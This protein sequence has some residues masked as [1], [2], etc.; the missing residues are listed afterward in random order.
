MCDTP[1]E[2]AAGWLGWG[3]LPDAPATIA[4]GPW[5]DLSHLLS[6]DMPRVSFFP[7]PRFEQIWQMPERPINVT[8]M[9]MVVH[10]GTHIDAPRHFFEDGPALDQIPLERLHGP[11]VVVAVDKAPGQ[12]VTAA[13]L[14]AGPPVE[15]GDIVALHTG[16]WRKAGSEAY[17]DHP[18][19]SEDAARW[20]VERRVKLVA[21]DMPTPD[22]PVQ[23]RPDGFNWPVHHI[24]LGNGVLI[25]EHLTGHGH[26]VDRRAE[27]VINALNIAGSDGAPARVLARP[28]AEV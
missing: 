24:L 27:F 12:L 18:S 16:W 20:L 23:R 19:L 7:P 17:D 25:C 13:D 9:Q 21:V 26:L 1:T 6:P 3:D 28:I 4:T 8:E 14:E 2:T 10:V 22:L 15:P 5:A 11:G